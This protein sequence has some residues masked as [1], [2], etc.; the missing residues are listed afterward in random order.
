MSRKIVVFAAFGVLLLAIGWMA[1][2]T[3]NASAT[4]ADGRITITATDMR[5]APDTITLQ[6]GQKVYLTFRNEGKVLHEIIFVGFKDERGD[7][8]GT[9]AMPGETNGANF[10]AP[11]AGAYVFL[12]TVPGHQEAGMVGKLI[13]R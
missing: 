10:T 9:K 7:G 5:Y 13:V 8:V 11:P 2:Q 12:C 6:A 4:S 3:S 1:Y